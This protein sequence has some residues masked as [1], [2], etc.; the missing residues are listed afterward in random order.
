MPWTEIDSA[1]LP[2]G[3]VMTLRQYGDDFEIR[4]GLYE[5]MSSRN[6][7]SERALA[8]IVTARLGR[9]VRSALIGGLGLG[10][11]LRALLDA[12]GPDAA[13]TVAE[14]VPAVVRWNRGPLAALASHPLDDRRV[15]VF[16]GDVAAAMAASPGA[17]DVILLDVDNGP[18]AVMFAGNTGLYGRGGVDLAQGALTPGGIVSV[19]AADASPA[20]ENVLENASVTVERHDISLAGRLCHTLYVIRPGAGS[21][22]AKMPE[23]KAASGAC[24]A[25]QRSI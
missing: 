8:E 2:D 20:F 10:Y 21:R 12:T 9:P 15:T 1:R 14:L 19:W 3:E 6:P 22:L 4:I 25:A 24:K 13:I 23:E 11:T 16:A 5:L 7:A 18:E 17:Y